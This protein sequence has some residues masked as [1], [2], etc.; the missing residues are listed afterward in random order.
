MFNSAPPPTRNSTT[1][2]PEKKQSPKPWESLHKQILLRSQAGKA[3]EGRQVPTQ[4]DE[5]WYGS[6]RG[7]KVR[8][9]RGVD[10]VQRGQCRQEIRWLQSR[11]VEWGRVSTG[12]RPVHASSSRTS[13]EWACRRRCS[14]SS[15]VVPP[16]NGLSGDDST[17]ALE[18]PRG[19]RSMPDASNPFPWP[20]ALHPWRRRK[21]GSCTHRAAQ[22]R[23]T[24]LFLHHAHCLP[25]PSPLPCLR[26]C[27][28]SS[29]VGCSQSGDCG[30][31][32][33]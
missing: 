3:N 30:G 28:L 1:K 33:A 10:A 21:R 9:R 16:C 29:D 24:S 5:Q 4:S 15:T 2:Q 25:L 11:R 18:S 32:S 23:T 17:P 8:D 12:F 27:T 7:S 13:H 26:V 31:Q 14:S 22:A 20:A 19:G 6:V